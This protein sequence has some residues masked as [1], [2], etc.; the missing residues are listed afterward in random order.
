[1]PKVNWDS[2][3]DRIEGNNATRKKSDLPNHFDN[4]L[5]QGMHEALG[6]NAAQREIANA[7]LRRLTEISHD[8]NANLN[9]GSRMYE[10]RANNK[11]VKKLL[12]KNKK[13]AEKEKKKSMKKKKKSKK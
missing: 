9:G 10:K 7:E 8:A 4:H 6:L 2:I 11:Y 1:M 3:I 5:F 13:A 12:K